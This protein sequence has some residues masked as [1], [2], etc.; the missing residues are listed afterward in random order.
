MKQYP[1]SHYQA[2][3]IGSSRIRRIIRLFKQRIA[4]NQFYAEADIVSAFII[5]S[6]INIEEIN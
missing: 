5:R 1:I 4:I 3:I 2:H 6:N